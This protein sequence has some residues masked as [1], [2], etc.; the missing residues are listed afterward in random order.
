MARPAGVQ[1]PSTPLRFAQ[2]DRVV[3][4]NGRGAPR[5]RPHRFLDMAGWLRDA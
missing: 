3:V 5:G 1:V 2:D 4:V